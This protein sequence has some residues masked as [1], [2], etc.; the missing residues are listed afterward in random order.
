MGVAVVSQRFCCVCGTGHA[1]TVACPGELRAT[2]TERP[3]WRVEVETPL[4]HEAIGVLLAPSYDQWRARIVTYPNVLWRAPGGRGTI[5]FV[6]GTREEA[7]MQA[8]RFIEAHLR[9]KR[10]PRREGPAPADV[11]AAAANEH[12]AAGSKR[13]LLVAVKR[14]TRCL[15]VR[16]GTDR[17]STRGMTLNVSPDG[18]FVHVAT[19]LESGGSLVLHLELDGQTV[20]MRGLVMWVRRRAEADRPIGMGIRLANPPPFYQSFVAALA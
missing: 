7:E 15:P 12:Q 4:G 10:S 16:F 1:D 6:G 20:P 17:A 18:M 19:P 8:I 13:P 3:G 11:M 5:K 14:K 9:A 2:G